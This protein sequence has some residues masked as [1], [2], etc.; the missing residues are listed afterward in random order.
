MIIKL[1]SHLT[2]LD[3]KPEISPIEHLVVGIIP[4]NQL[5]CVC[6]EFNCLSWA[7]STNT[8]GRLFAFHIKRRQLKRSLART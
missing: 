2:T 5:V 8:G 6:V 3:L 7:G 1:N 4:Y